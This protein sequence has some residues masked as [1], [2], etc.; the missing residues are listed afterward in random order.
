MATMVPGRSWCTVDIQLGT[1]TAYGL[2]GPL[3]DGDYLRRVAV[4][5]EAD[6]ATQGRFAAT[7]G[8][9]GEASEGAFRTGVPIIQRSTGVTYNVPHYFFY[10]VAGVPSWFWIPVGIVGSVGSRY[11]VFVWNAAG[12]TVNRTIMVSLDVMRLA[13]DRKD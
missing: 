3:A 2:L 1:A 12:E 7:L 4:T 8:A 11:V 6:A 5:I 9:S 13:R 10:V